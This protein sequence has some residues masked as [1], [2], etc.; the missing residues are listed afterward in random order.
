M[1]L[2]FWHICK[3]EFFDQGL[4]QVSND[5]GVNWTPI[6]DGAASLAIGAIAISPSSPEIVYV[7]TGEATF[8][9]SS[10]F[11]VGVYRINNA[12]TTANVS[13]P[14]RLDA[15]SADIFSGRAIGRIIVHPTNPDIIFVGSTSGIGGIL[16][17][18]TGLTLPSRVFTV[19][20]MLLRQ[21]R[22]L[23]N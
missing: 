16:G 15:T 3:L 19:A 14:F 21:H 7:G 8:S 12:S 6:F 13:G 22:F 4:I 11:G 17:N 5:G 1:I 10:F 20:T 2:N 9:G 23:Q 18:S